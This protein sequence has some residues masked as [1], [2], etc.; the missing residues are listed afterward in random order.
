VSSEAIIVLLEVDELRLQVGS[1]PE[2]CLVEILAPDGVDT[3]KRG[4]VR[5]DN[6]WPLPA[7][8]GSGHW[9]ID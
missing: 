3:E 9:V 8:L 6:S 2:Q 5:V 1:R 4:A 7:G